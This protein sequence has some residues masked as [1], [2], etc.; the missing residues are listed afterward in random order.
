MFESH[1]IN[2]TAAAVNA[3]SVSSSGSPNCP[4]T[5]ALAASGTYGAACSL[6]SST[7]STM[8]T[9]ISAPATG[10]NVTATRKTSMSESQQFPKYL[11]QLT[12]GENLEKFPD[13]RCPLCFQ[14]K[15]HHEVIEAVKY[16]RQPWRIRER[17]KTASVAL[18]LCLNIGVDPPDVIKIQPCARLECWIDPSSLSAPKAMD[19]IGSN[20]QMQYERW[21][22]RARYKKC[23]DPTVEDVKKLCTSLRR[24]AKGERILFH[25]NGHGV[26]KP[27]VNGEIWVFNKTFTQYIPLSIF[28]LQTWMAAPSIYVYDCSNAGIII[29]SFLQFAEQHEK[30]ANQRVPPGG[31]APSISPMISYKNCIHLAACSVGEILPMNAQLPADLFT[32]CLT[33]PINIALKWYTMREK[34]GLVPQ[35]QSDVIDKIPGKVNDRRTMM[36]ELNWVFTA[37]TDTIAW[38]TLP[39][40]LF[41]KLFRQDLLVASLFRNFLLAERILRSHD[42]T[43]VSHPALPPCFRHPM[44]TAWD[45]VVDLALQ[46]LP[47]ILKGGAPYKQL[48]F[49]EEQLTA[50]QVWLD[51][52][53][54]SRTPPEQLPI[55]LQVLLSQVHRLRALELLAR[56][57]DLGPWAVNLALGVG[58]FPYVLKLLQ[59]SAKEL[60]PV[61]VFIWAKILAVDPSCQ[62]DLVK[63]HKYFLAVLQD[64]TVAK[65]YRTLSAFVLA[66]IVNNFLLGQTSALQGS[67]VSICLE[68][69]N[70]ESWL[71]RQWLAICLG[72]LWHNFEK[73]RW[74]G[75]RDLAHEKLYPLLKDPIPEVRAAAVFALG[76]FI[77][78]VTD[79]SEEH[80]N[81]IDRIIAITLLEN[82]A[83]DMSPL[84]RLEL[85]S[86]LQWMVL[87]FES[88]FVT[89][90]MQEHMTSPSVSSERS[91]SVSHVMPGA[92]LSTASGGHGVFHHHSTH[93]LE[94]HATM[95]RGVSSSS[96]SNISSS[97]IPFQSIFLKLWQGIYQ[98][99]HDPFPKVAETAREI[100]G[101][102]KN[103][104]LLLIT[105]KEA[106][107][108]KCISL[109][110]SLP[111][112][113]NTRV[114]YLGGSGS[115]TGESPPVGVGNPGVGQGSGSPWASKLRNMHDPQAMLHRKLRTTSMSDETDSA[116]P[117]ISIALSEP[118]GGNNGGDG[119]A[120][121]HSSTS[122]TNFES[123]SQ[124]LK[125]IV[126]TEFIPWAISYFTKPGKHRYAADKNSER[127]QIFPIDKNA[128]ILRARECRFQRNRQ[129]RSQARNQ[130]SRSPRIDTQSWVRKTQSTPS[131]VRLLP[132]EQQIAVAYREKVLLYDWQRNT[133]RTF[134]PTSVPSAA[135]SSRNRTSSASPPAHVP[136]NNSVAR[137]SAIEFL[138]SQDMPLTLVGHDDGVVRIWQPNAGNGTDEYSR[139][140]PGRL[141]TAWIALPAMHASYLGNS[142][143]LG[144]SCTKY[145]RKGI[146]GDGCGLVTA[147]QQCSQQLVVAGGTSRFLRIWDVERE[148]RLS[149]IPIGSE[150]SIRVLSPFSTNM[151]SDI[152]VGGC[153]DGSVRLYDKR[154]APQEA[155]IRVYREHTGAILSAC[156]RDTQTT[157]VTGCSNGKISV[158]DLRSKMPNGVLSQWDAG[159]DVTV[160]AS[161]QSADMIAAGSVNKITIYSSQQGG[162]LLS[163]LRSNDSFMG[164]KIGHPTCLAFHLHKISLAVGFVD[165]TVAVYEPS[166]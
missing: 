116:A 18:V 78:S 20:L 163:T 95:R 146:T 50:F 150:H 58:I 104:A 61:L 38:N 108:E 143:S 115:G 136:Q 40:E 158:I 77:S 149:D 72:M 155:R 46:Q 159:N 83:E 141:V 71:L 86:A 74:S 49:F 45:L 126:T 90:Y 120:S 125:P 142:S 76:T 151:S 14:A 68:Q 39:R 7:I 106:A 94:R 54:E 124:S 85:A 117:Q 19:L 6:A 91:A 81:N 140:C 25:Y 130:Q 147:W 4:P 44:W 15:R 154:C 42:C 135:T 97:A 70:D 98:L 152:I 63:D 30:E 100:I 66:C 32:S 21:Q 87:L 55:V 145:T 99:S 27:T 111:P 47:D 53:S 2:T 166:S 12:L 73:A 161:H 26:P 139:D 88:Q 105:A 11:Q 48:P 119:S 118:V 35:L 121:G 23:H 153:G 133:V 60:R 80:A 127:I 132:Y 112:S 57:L 31:P 79:R 148:L 122:D 67:L 144:G 109:S 62:V 22:P 10:A 17:M 162:R 123:K 75:V 137:V 36:G 96:I 59:S 156:L 114:S 84:V 128:P 43:P 24:N 28:E 29:Q 69:L 93:S 64:T 110:V 52:E 103:A 101:F 157:L 164:P 56:F 34:F 82:V 41:Q 51:R 113:P 165:N 102:I 9:S 92:P 3:S 16:E 134:T 138:N 1:Y 131:L 107:N 5:S 8:A 13:H 160:I 37:I 33:T 129:I 89:V 65:E